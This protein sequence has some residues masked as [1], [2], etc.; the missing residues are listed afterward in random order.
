MTRIK[1]YNLILPGIKP[2]DTL[3]QTFPNANKDNQKPCKRDIFLL[4]FS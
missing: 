2:G 1:M 4:K 3:I